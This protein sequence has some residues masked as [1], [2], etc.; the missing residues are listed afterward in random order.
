MTYRKGGHHLVCEVSLWLGGGLNHIDD[1]LSGID[2]RIVTLLTRVNT[3]DA[4]CMVI[5]S[6]M[7]TLERDAAKRIAGTGGLPD[8]D[9]SR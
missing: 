9:A 7:H 4:K 3:I 1:M 5:M 8:Y 6:R 2:S